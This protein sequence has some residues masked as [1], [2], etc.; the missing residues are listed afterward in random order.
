MKLISKI[1]H[2]SGLTT[3]INSDARFQMT[4]VDFI[5]IIIFLFFI[6]QGLFKGLLLEFFGLL[7]LV[8]GILSAINFYTLGAGWF[9]KI[10][11]PDGPLRNIAGFVAVFLIVWLAIK[12]MGWILN[13]NMGE[14]ETNSLSRIAG[15]AIGLAKSI[16]FVSMIVYLAEN[17]FPDNKFTGPNKSTPVLIKIVNKAQEITPFHFLP[18]ISDSD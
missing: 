15:G 1:S 3:P 8:A 6:L 14:A 5:I 2:N 17:A 12:I 10:F 7:A 18:D 11:P 4:V 9:E 16:F 13:K